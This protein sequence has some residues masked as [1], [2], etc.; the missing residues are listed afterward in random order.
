[1]PQS[2]EMNAN[3]AC[4]FPLLRRDFL[5]QHAGPNRVQEGPFL[6][7]NTASDETKLPSRVSGNIRTWRVVGRPQIGSTESGSMSLASALAL[8]NPRDI[9]VSAGMFRQ[10]PV[11]GRFKSPS[12]TVD[13]VSAG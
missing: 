3:R 7:S 13:S 4:G 11:Q 5:R 10:Q 8:D 6:G 9:I 1:V 12:V 2:E